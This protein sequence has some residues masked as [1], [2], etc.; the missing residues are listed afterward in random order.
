[1]VHEE[2]FGVLLLLQSVLVPEEASE[3]MLRIVVKVSRIIDV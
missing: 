3:V 2:L 1:M